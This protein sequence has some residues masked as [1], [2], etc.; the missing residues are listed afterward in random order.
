MAFRSGWPKVEVRRTEGI[1]AK[2]DVM[3]NG[4][5]TDA[6]SGESL[7]NS[8][9]WLGFRFLPNVEILSDALCGKSCHE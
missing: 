6:A 5:V 8:C 1:S 7:V 3:F 2:H 9:H 4:G